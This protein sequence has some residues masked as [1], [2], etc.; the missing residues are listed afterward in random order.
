MKNGVQAGNGLVTFTYPA[1]VTGSGK[2]P[3]PAS[4]NA[5]QKEH[6]L[7]P[8]SAVSCQPGTA[9]TPTD[10]FAIIK[11]ANNTV[12]AQVALKNAV[13]NVTY[14]VFLVQTPT[15]SG[16]ADIAGTIQTSGQG[17]G[18]VHVSAPLSGGATGA[19]VDVLAKF[20]GSSDFQETTN[21]AFGS[22]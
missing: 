21:Y 20:G 10:S 12:S 3:P 15:G 18:N 9:G 22:K 11:N 13:P 4:S 14:A 2:P 5:A 17:N 7:H 6:F 8:T 16:C 19:F 1:P